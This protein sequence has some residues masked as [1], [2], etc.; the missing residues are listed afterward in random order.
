MNEPPNAFPEYRSLDPKS[1]IGFVSQIQPAREVLG[2]SPENWQTREVGDGN[3][4]LV[5]IV[6]GTK[7]AVVVKQ[8]LPYLRCVGEAWALPLERAYFENEALTEQAKFVPDP[9]H[10]APSG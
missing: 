9:S 1:V 3:L 2:S 5:F 7:G 8:A 10:V 4:N 6:S